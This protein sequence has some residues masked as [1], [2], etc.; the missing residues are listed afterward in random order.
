[1]SDPSH[2]LEQERKWIEDSK[3]DIGCFRPL[4]EK[5]CDQV[6]RYLVR[7]TDD[8]EMAEDLCSTTFI[9]AMDNL[10]KFVWQGK[11]FGAWLFRIAQN[12]LRKHFRNKK[13]VFVIE[14]E[15][16][17]AIE[18]LEEAGDPDF[19]NMLIEEL[20]HLDDLELRLLELRFFE[21]ASFKEIS[22][23][24]SMGESAVKMRIYRLLGKLKTRLLRNHDQA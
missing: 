1:M 12:E 16:V 22:D 24:L 3:G 21:E 11:P 15:K 5:Y 20:D 13:P 2:V 8:D 19:Q 6:Y 14:I 23:L 9:R 4:Y 7:R 10:D 18:D 17:E